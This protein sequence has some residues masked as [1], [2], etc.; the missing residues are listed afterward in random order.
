MS[1]IAKKENS[2]LMMLAQ[3]IGG[4]NVMELLKYP[5]TSHGFPGNSPNQR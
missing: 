1:D 4:L 5:T 2:S 3:A